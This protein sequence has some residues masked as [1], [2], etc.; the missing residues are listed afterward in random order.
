MSL[1]WLPCHSEKIPPPQS[2]DIK[3]RMMDS[4][5][6]HHLR[7]PALW[8]SRRNLKIM[9]GYLER[10]TERIPTRDIYL[11][12]QRRHLL[13]PLS[14]QISSWIKPSKHTWGDL[15]KTWI[16]VVSLARYHYRD[17]KENGLTTKMKGH[18]KNRILTLQYYH[19]FLLACHLAGRESR[20]ANQCWHP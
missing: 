6:C 7:L 20:T 15:W 16:L 10:R 5:W 11:L 14:T 13:W 4:T 17:Q 3:A 9:E 8:L 2:N 1:G 12:N 18:V 19:N